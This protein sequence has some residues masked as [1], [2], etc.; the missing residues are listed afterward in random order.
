VYPATVKFQFI[1]SSNGKLPQRATDLAA[2]YDIYSGEDCIVPSYE[3]YP[4][5]TG[6]KI[7]PQRGYVVKIYV[8]SGMAKKGVFLANGTG[9]IDADYSGELIILL[10]NST[11]EP[12]HVELGHRIAQ[13]EVCKVEDIRFI[14][15]HNIGGEHKGFGSTGL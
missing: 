13:M 11:I 9:I 6:I 5:H 2:F 4:V 10:Y 8:R 12:Y 15:S 7:Q 1:K 3:V 14:E